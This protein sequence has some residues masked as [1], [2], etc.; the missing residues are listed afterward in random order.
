MQRCL[1]FII[2]DA[3]C[4]WI[5]LDDVSED[6]DRNIVAVF[7]NIREGGPTSLVSEGGLAR[8]SEECF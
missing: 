6:F 4:F 5:A 7:T 1:A 2:G 8:I 3:R